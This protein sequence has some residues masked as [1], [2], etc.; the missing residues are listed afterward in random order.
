MKRRTSRKKLQASLHRFT[1][2]VR[3]HRHQMRTGELLRRAATRVAGHL[4]HYAVTDNLP[5]CRTYVYWAERI[6]RRW[7]HRRSQRRSYP[8]SAFRRALASA[9]WPALHIRRALDPFRGMA[10]V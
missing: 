9:G 8:W 10:T 2:W 5:R 1:D 6:L 7:L 4:A 3:T